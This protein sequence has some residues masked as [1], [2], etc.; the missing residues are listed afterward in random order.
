MKRIKI[1]IDKAGRTTIL[2]AE[3]YGTGCVLATAGMEARL[4]SADE[5]SRAHTSNMHADPE[6]VAA[7]QGQ[8]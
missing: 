4:G 5:S 8:G 1:K 3:G 2:D 7:E 6:G